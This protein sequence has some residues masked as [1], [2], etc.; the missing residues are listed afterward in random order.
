MKELVP[1][2]GKLSLKITIAYRLCQPNQDILL[3]FPVLG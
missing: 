3:C 2:S 1:D